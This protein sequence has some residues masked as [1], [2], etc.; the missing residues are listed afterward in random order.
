LFDLAACLFPKLDVGAASGRSKTV[1]SVSVVVS[2]MRMMRFFFIASREP[3]NGIR[4]HS[5]GKFWLQP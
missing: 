3:V 1:S 5:L 2:A 4:D